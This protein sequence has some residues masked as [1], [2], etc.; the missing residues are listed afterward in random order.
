MMHDSCQWASGGY[1]TYPL[2][3]RIQEQKVAHSG[4]LELLLRSRL[5]VED[6]ATVLHKVGSIIQPI[7]K[8]RLTEQKFIPFKPALS[9][10]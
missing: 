6:T 2:I 7:A 4:E 9:H 8:R 10:A 5:I 3:V 1:A